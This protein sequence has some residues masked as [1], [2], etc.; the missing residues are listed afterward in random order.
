MTNTFV[1]QPNSKHDYLEKPQ[2]FLC[3][4]LHAIITYVLKVAVR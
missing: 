3:D 4:Y 2:M 1:L